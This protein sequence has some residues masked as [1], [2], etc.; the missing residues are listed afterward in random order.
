M[1]IDKD[2]YCIVPIEPTDSLLCSMAMRSRHDFDLMTE[3]QQLAMKVNMSQLHE[4]VIGAG[5]Y[6][7][8]T[9]SLKIV[10]EEEWGALVKDAAR[11]RWLIEKGPRYHNAVKGSASMSL[12]RGPYIFLEVPAMNPFCNL[13]LNTKESADGIIDAANT[14]TQEAT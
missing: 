14:A 5:F 9:T 4:E 10:T 3:K 11:Y 13:I 7:E 8:P 6:K 1:T 2:Q 12:G